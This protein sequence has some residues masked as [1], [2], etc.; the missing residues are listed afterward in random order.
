MSLSKQ[1]LLTLLALLA[2]LALTV[3]AA[4]LPIGAAQL[5]L[6]L[7]ISIAKAVLIVHVFMRFSH[8]TGVARL[9]F[10]AGFVWLVIIATLSLSDYLTR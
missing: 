10:A 6:A 7:L 4:Y 9:A 5:P 3:G 2:L 1:P 8:G